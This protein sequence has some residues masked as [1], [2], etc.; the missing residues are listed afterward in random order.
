MRPT[1]RRLWDAALTGVP[2][3]VFKVALGAWLIDHGPAPLGAA[4]VGWG[5]LDIALNLAAVP[6][7]A[8]SYCALSNLGRRVGREDLLLAIDTFLSFAIVAVMVGL[9]L[10]RELP[11]PLRR[12]YDLAV[13]L[14]VLAA[15]V[16]RLWSV[17]RA[18]REA[19]AAGAPA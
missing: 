13:V 9:G 6:L 15:G 17:A 10:V 5:V 7:P 2:F 8:V 4:V 12:A 3:G 16:E 1:V 18:R 11:D 14:N 19:Q